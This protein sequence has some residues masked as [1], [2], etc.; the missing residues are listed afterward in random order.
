[1]NKIFIILKFIFSHR[2]STSLPFPFKKREKE[3]QL[4]TFF[5]YFNVIE[6][7]IISFNNTDNNATSLNFQKNN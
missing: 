7:I 6:I 1:M 2:S 5:I 3:H 4:K